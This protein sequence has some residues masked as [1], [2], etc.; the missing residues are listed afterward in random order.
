[1]GQPRVTEH[2]REHGQNVVNTDF[3]AEH[4]EITADYEPGTNG[5]RGYA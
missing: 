5:R 3:I 2:I 1:M 4:E